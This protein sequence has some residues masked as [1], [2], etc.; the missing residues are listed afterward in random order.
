MSK[1]EPVEEIPE[2]GNVTII[3]GASWRA[4]ISEG[5]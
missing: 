3:D 2:R 4:L 1:Y 5:D